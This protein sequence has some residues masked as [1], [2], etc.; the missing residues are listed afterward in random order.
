MGRHVQARL[1][2]VVVG[3]GLTTSIWVLADAYAV[4]GLV[5][6]PGTLPGAAVLAW[7]GNWVWIPGWTLTGL[8]F[9]VFREGHL[10]SPRW[11]PFAWTFVASGVAFSAASILTHG[12]LAN[13]TFV[14]NP[15]GAL[16]V[17]A[18]TLKLAG[19]LALLGLG[20]VA[21]TSLVGRARRAR[22]EQRLQ[23][24]WVC[25]AG[26]LGRQPRPA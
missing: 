1:D 23:Y 11:R 10:P 14:D 2:W 13:Y 20:L 26:A 17:G 6:Q 19:S 16:R 4:Y 21:V 8:L 7:L 5:D 3:I 12:P 15:F 25:Y 18:A 24:Q 9:L 22:G